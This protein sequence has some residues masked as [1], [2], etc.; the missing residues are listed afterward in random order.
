MNDNPQKFEDVQEKHS[1]SLV[2]PEINSKDPWKDDV[3]GR[4]DVAG[5]LTNLVRGQK[6]P[7]VISLDGHWGTGKTFLLKRWEKELCNKNFKAIYFNAWEDD[8]HNDPLVAIIGQL[9]N[10]FPEEKFKKTV[11]K[12]KES[13]IPLLRQSLLS[14]LNMITGM[15]LSDDFFKEL[16]DAMLTEYSSAKA[17]KDTLKKHLQ[18]MSEE[19][20]KE[21]NQPLVFIVDEMDRCRPTFSIELLERVKHI[22]DIPGIV[23]V[24]GI[25]QKELRH[26]IESVY[27]E[28]ESDIYLRRFFDISLSLPDANAVDFCRYLIN[29][30]YQL[31]KLFNELD[32]ATEH[33]IHKGEFN[34]FSDRFIFFYNHFDLSLRD[35]DSCIRSMFFVAKNIQNG[36]SMHPFLIGTFIALRL[37]EPSLY[38]KFFKGKCHGADIMNYIDDKI[39]DYELHSPIGDTLCGIELN[40]YT[41]KT[42]ALDQLSLLQNGQELTHPEYLSAKTLQNKGR[43]SKLLS[44]YDRMQSTFHGIDLSHIYRL[45]ELTEV[46]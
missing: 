17:S 43:E 21:T 16:S 28:I 2:E 1:L 35:I 26:S 37:Q 4:A 5:K 44:Y 34:A 41:T 30:R 33:N 36:Y 7:L 23:F 19:V 9:S 11:G 18:E 8:F 29:E 32:M 39:P 27:G 31:N 46:E 12:I 45:I 15:A 22:F 38:R 14:T 13:A 3:L 24:F 6:T 10:A 25:N 42:E 40:L 20:I